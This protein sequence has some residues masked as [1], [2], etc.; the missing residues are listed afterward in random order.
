M[1]SWCHRPAYTG[2]LLSRWYA[3]DG[4]LACAKVRSPGGIRLCTRWGS[5]IGRAINGAERLWTSQGA[6][7]A[8]GHAPGAGVYKHLGGAT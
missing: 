4:L 8:G 3:V 1:N 6:L 7:Q 5:T 2:K